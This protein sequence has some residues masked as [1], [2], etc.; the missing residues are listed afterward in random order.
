M[1]LNITRCHFLLKNQGIS[2]L[3]RLISVF[4]TT[5]MLKIVNLLYFPLAPFARS[6]GPLTRL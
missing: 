6:I 3:F 4:E 1:T 5:A 2:I